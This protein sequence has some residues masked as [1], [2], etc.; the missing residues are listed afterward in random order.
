MMEVVRAEFQERHAE[1]VILFDHIEV[2]TESNRVNLILILKSSLF[3]ALYNNVEA[4]IYSLFERVHQEALRL[5]YDEL[6]KKM[7]IILLEYHF[8]KGRSVNWEQFNNLHVGH[9]RFPTLKEYL[10]RLGLFSGNLDVREVRRIFLKY[11]VLPYTLPKNKGECLLTIKSK[12]NSIAHGSERM[13]QAGQG[14]KNERLRRLID[15]SEEVLGHVIDKVDDY[16]K[17]RLFTSAP[18]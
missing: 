2:L 15:D 5:S 7:Q 18:I 9:V 12:R 8:D 1:I 14:F 16:L 11:G 6:S 10:E 3:I 17:R 13:I 4:T